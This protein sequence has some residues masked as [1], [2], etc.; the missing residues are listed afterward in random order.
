MTES[1]FPR[2]KIFHKEPGVIVLVKFLRTVL[3]AFK[4]LDMAFA[5]GVL[6]FFTKVQGKTLRIISIPPQGI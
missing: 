1:M 3:S 2:F 6:F 4:V 5:F